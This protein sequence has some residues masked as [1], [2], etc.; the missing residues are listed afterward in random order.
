MEKNYTIS[1]LFVN[2][3][4]F[5]SKAVYYLLGG[6]FSH[7]SIG[8]DEGDDIFYSFNMKGF[9]R[10][11][12]RKHEGIISRSECYKL[13]VSKEEHEKVKQMIELFQ[14]KRFDWKF[15]LVG[16]LL[17]TVHVRFRKRHHYYCSEFVAELLQKT[18]IGNFEKNLAYYSPNRLR[19]HMET[20]RNV[21]WVISNPFHKSYV[22]IV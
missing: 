20:F 13:N 12:P 19:K 21:E 18:R 15:N 3:E 8:L 2:Y 5:W 4:D 1:V 7:A 9:R 22:N 17:S 6:G 10:E 11:Q 14:R 16:L